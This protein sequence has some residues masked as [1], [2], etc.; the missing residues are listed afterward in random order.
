MDVVPLLLPLPFP[1]PLPLPFHY[2]PPH[3]TWYL[4]TTRLFT[5][6]IPYTPTYIRYDLRSHVPC[7]YS[8]VFQTLF[9]VPYRISDI[10]YKHPSLNFSVLHS[11]YSI[12]NPQ[13]SILSLNVLESDPPVTLL[14]PLLLLKRENF[15]W[16]SLLP[17][18]SPFV[19]S[20]LSF[21]PFI[22]FVTN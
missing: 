15:L 12:L 3:T 20:L 18:L 19:F 9:P 11:Q 5:I 10:R 16:F 13:S 17:C 6:H 22:G 8:L 21:C 7:F 2:I 4:I 14:P 1:L